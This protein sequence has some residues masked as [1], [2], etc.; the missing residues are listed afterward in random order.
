VTLPGGFSEHDMPIGL[1]LAGRD[2][3]TLIRAAVVFRH[4]TPWHRPHPLLQS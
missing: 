3:T 2:E 1:Q 4:E